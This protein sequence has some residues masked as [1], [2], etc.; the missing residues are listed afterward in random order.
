[1]TNINKNSTLNQFRDLVEYNINKRLDY[2]PDS[3]NEEQINALEL[4]RNRIFLEE[5]IEE[6]ILFNQKLSWENLNNNLRLVS[7]AEDLIEVFKLRSDIFH[8]VGYGNVFSDA[9]E[10]LNFD[11]FDK[12]SAIIYY[13]S[14][15]EVTATVRLIF[16]SEQKLPC[17]NI[18]SF[19]NLR[20]QYNT[21]G[22]L[23]RNA[24]KRQSS[25]LNLEFKYLMSGIHNVFSNNDIDI[26]VSGIK[27]DNYKLCSKFGG[28]EIL[29]DL[30]LFEK[31]NEESM[32][33][34]WDLS[35]KSKFF[36]K[37]ILN[38]NKNYKFE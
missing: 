29:K 37:A 15:N 24:I 30:G 26:T 16:D 12:N 27:S 7:S 32:I 17:D 10:G 5:V 31:T 8:S 23:S 34:S 22:E 35:K 14:Q 1:M 33:I 3:F 25:K 19:D 28:V 2:M 9:M 13:T 6:S 20:K 38:K 11:I 21:I 4:F 18:L 36:D